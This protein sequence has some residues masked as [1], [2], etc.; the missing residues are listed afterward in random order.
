MLCT[1]VLS[2][3][4]LVRVAGEGLTA[5]GRLYVGVDTKSSGVG[6]NVDVTAAQCSV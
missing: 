1:P 2:K 6:H 4:S 5:A 3:W